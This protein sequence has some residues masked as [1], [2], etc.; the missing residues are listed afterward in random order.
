MIQTAPILNPAKEPLMYLSAFTHPRNLGV[1][2]LAEGFYLY[3]LAHPTQN[4]DGVYLSDLRAKTT[5]WLNQQPENILQTQDL[6]A[7]Q[8]LT[9]L[10]QRAF[11]PNTYVELALLYGGI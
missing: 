4:S 5:D 7:V 1:T 6:P 2:Q 11:V 9:R 10:N 3:R 8:F